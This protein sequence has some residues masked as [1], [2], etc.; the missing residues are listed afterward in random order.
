MSNQLEDERKRSLAEALKG[1]SSEEDDTTKTEDETPD[2]D[3]TEEN[4]EVVQKSSGDGEDSPY[5]E[6]DEDETD[7]SD[8]V[9]SSE[10]YDTPEDRVLNKVFGGD[11]QKLSKGYL[12]SQKEFG[13]LQRQFKQVQSELEK[14]DATVKNVNR[15]LQNF[16]QLEDALV[17][18]SKGEDINVESLF[19]QKPSGK[20]DTSSSKGKFNEVDNEFL[21][22]VNKLIDSGYLNENKLEG[23]SDFDR[24]RMILN[25]KSQYMTNELPNVVQGM[26]KQQMDTV[27]EQKQEESRVKNIQT[28]NESRMEDG[29]DRAVAEYG[30]EFSGKD[31][32][33][34]DEI[35]DE[36][37]A[38][39]D[40][41]NRE[42]IRENAVD[43]AVREVLD[44]RG[45]SATKK[46]PET[47][48][49]DNSNDKSKKR[50][51]STTGKSGSEPNE[52]TSKESLTPEE[53]MR[54]RHLENTT[55][56]IRSRKNMYKTK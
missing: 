15:A 17:K 44:R 30:L 42:L 12:E 45:R 47:K 53:M 20:S 14:K 18:A 40:S 41:S 29:F 35:Y 9:G 48:K 6:D 4:D 43:I 56:Q 3:P 22:D 51:F 1:N 16:P 50:M 37:T 13:K 21:P 28:Q 31:K 19:S 7:G 23:L 49:T 34:F 32:E 26:V 27:A 5:L 8:T 11:E 24:D 46:Q 52:A 2:D 39:R 36:A 55:S 33:L 54:Q 38:F 10:S 25:A